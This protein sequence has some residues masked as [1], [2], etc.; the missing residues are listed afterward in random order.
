MELD[1]HPQEAQVMHEETGMV[2]LALGAAAVAMY[3]SPFFLFFLPP[4][5]RGIPLYLTVPLGI[6]AIVFGVGTLYRMRG[7]RGASRRRAQAGIA[8]GTVTLVVPISLL[9]WLSWSLDR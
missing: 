9:V 2:S 8:L 7:S 6:C 3:G 5:I 4:L 1:E